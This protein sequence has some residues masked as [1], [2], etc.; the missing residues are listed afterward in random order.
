MP[1]RR[2]KAPMCCVLV[3]P[4]GVR[5]NIVIC[6]VSKSNLSQLLSLLGCYLLDL[7]ILL[8][9]PK[10]KRTLEK[11]KLGC[12]CTSPSISVE[13][14]LKD[15]WS[16]CVDDFHLQQERGDKRKFKYLFHMKHARA[17]WLEAT[18]PRSG[19]IRRKQ[20]ISI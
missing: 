10:L 20:D 4:E 17:H 15:T 2:S 5:H 7:S 13:W 8:L 9:V 12:N 14:E 3:L 19:N 6:S 1:F 18:R 16:S 11:K